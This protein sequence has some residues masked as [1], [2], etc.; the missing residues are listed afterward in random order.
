MVVITLTSYSMTYPP[1][2]SSHEHFEWMLVDSTQV[3]SFIHVVG[4]SSSAQ[5]LCKICASQEVI[6]VII[7]SS[8]PGKIAAISQ[9]TFSN[10][11][12]WMK[13]LV[14]Q[15]KFQFVPYGPIDSKPAF[16]YKMAWRRT[17]TNADPFHRRI[18][19]VLRGDWV[20]LVNEDIWYESLH[21]VKDTWKSFWSFLTISYNLKCR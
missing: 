12:N 15:F 21:S 3:L 5:C 9:T 4:L 13:N 11:F 1:T 10:P 19:A 20:K 7:K 18:H 6:R 2:C 8:S 14:F 17:W 16:A